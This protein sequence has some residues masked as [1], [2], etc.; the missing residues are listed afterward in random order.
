MNINKNIG[1]IFSLLLLTGFLGC[2][3]TEVQQEPIVE[4]DQKCRASEMIIEPE[5]LLEKMEN[6]IPIFLIEVSKEADFETGHIPGA[7]R[8]WRPDY[9][10]REH[11]A[12]TGMRADTQVV[13]RLLRKLGYNRHELLVLYDRRGDVDAA[14]LF[15]ILNMYGHTDVVLLNGGIDAWRQ[16]DF[17]LSTETTSQ[18]LRGNFSFLAKKKKTDLFMTKEHLLHAMQDSNV[19]IL[20]TRTTAEYA[21]EKQKKGAS[22]PGKIPG[23]IHLDWI[24]LVHDKGDYTFKTCE[25][26]EPLLLSRGISPDKKIIT[27]CHSGVRSAH[28]AF[29]LMEIMG[30][31]HVANYDGSWTEW[32]Y[33]KE[34]PI[35]LDNKKNINN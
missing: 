1:F 9:E 28:T 20:D 12:Y 32:S 27:Y 13:A 17:P 4:E 5:A 11:Y 34:L 30:Y 10:D 24:E 15:W 3:E 14:R 6:K 19:L 21:G 18:Q 22:R 16:K 31:P 26:I 33:Y 7:Q 25:E 29:V 8:V 2:A 23:S 35:T